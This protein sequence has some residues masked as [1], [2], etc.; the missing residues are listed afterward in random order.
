MVNSLLMWSHPRGSE[1]TFRKQEKAAAVKKGLDSLI[2]ETTRI[3]ECFPAVDTRARRV[4]SLVKLQ[5]EFV[6]LCWI[7][8]SIH[9]SRLTCRK[10]NAKMWRSFW[11][12]ELQ[13]SCFRACKQKSTRLLKLTLVF[14]KIFY[15]QEMCCFWVLKNH[16]RGFP[17]FLAAF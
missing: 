15:V 6:F 11:F 2:M 14:L 1:L 12:W 9:F 7:L 16:I 10:C 5:I 8:F 4:R 3:Q 13:L 17:H